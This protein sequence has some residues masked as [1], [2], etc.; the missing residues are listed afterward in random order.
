MKFYQEAVPQIL[1]KLVHLWIF[2][3]Q[4][5][6]VA[7]SKIGENDKILRLEVDDFVVM[8]NLKVVALN[9]LNVLAS[10]VPISYKQLL[11]L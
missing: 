3:Y 4:F 11:P 7:H 2:F 10:V 6:A 1:A 9:F 5:I 8:Y